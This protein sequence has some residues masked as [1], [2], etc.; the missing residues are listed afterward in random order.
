MTIRIE[1]ASV[2]GRAVFRV[3]GR[4]GWGNLEELRAEVQGKM[5]GATLDLEHV[6]LVDV[7]AVRFLNVCEAQGT[8]LRHCSAYIREWMSRERSR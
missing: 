3:S 7:E 5:E 1:K 2:D 8:E 4:I 6:T